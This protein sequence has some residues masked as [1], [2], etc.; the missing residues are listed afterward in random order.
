MTSKALICD[1]KQPI[2]NLTNEAFFQLVTDD[3][4]NLVNA[5]EYGLKVSILP[6][7]LFDW[8]IFTLIFPFLMIGIY[9]AHDLK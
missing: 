8:I 4:S 2:E 9:Y 7:L 6:F 5:K 1:I 3:Q